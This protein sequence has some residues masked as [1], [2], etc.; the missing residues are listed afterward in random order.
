[1]CKDYCSLDHLRWTAASKSLFW[2]GP[3]WRCV[4]WCN[5]AG[6]TGRLAGPLTALLSESRERRQLFLMSSYVSFSCA[7]FSLPSRK[8]SLANVLLCSPTHR[9]RWQR[10]VVSQHA[11]T[12]PLLHTVRG[13]Y[14]LWCHAVPI[15]HSR[16]PEMTRNPH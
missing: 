13:L 2:S 11:C 3:V 10:S 7:G 16:K 12:H 4:Q 9:R 6:V 5:G 15:N 1:M 8:C 14:K